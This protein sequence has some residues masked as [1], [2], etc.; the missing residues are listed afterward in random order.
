MANVYFVYLEYVKALTRLSETER[1]GSNNAAR[2]NDLHAKIDDLKVNQTN[3]DKGIDH[4]K[5][6]QKEI[7]NKGV[8]E[9]RIR[10]EEDIEIKNSIEAVKNSIMPG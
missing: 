8:E 6:K 1:Q 2:A 5:L 9:V 3:L 10:E 4:L 7:E